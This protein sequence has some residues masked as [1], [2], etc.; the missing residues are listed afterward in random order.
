LI[1][2]AGQVVARR[3]K[4]GFPLCDLGLDLCLA[5]VVVS[6]ADVAFQVELLEA[7]PLEAK[8]IQCVVDVAV[9]GAGLEA[10]RHFLADEGSQSWWYAESAK[11]VEGFGFQ[12]VC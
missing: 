6:A 10:L 3:A 11:E 4:A 9:L 8:V 1:Q 12:L 7:I 2:D 5:G